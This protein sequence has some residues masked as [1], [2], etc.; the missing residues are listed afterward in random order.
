MIVLKTILQTTSGWLLLYL[1]L[2]TE[3]TLNL[4]KVFKLLANINDAL[5]S[6]VRTAVR[7]P[8]YYV[9]DIFVF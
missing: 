3:T 5:V 2:Y 1:S 4:I 6:T 9:I 7:E 8:L